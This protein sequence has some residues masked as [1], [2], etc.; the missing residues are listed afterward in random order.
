M[1]SK[2]PVSK[3]VGENFGFDE[4]SRIFVKNENMTQ[5][6]TKPMV[7]ETKPRT[8]EPNKPAQPSRKN[9]PFL[10]E[11]APGIKTDPKANA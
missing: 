6:T 5:P 1:W 2:K 9:K 8:T 7:P 3:I 4:N 11:V 10:P